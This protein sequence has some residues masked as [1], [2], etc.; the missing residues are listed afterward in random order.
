MRQLRLRALDFHQVEHRKPP[1]RNLSLVSPPNN[2]TTIHS[3]KS[4]VISLHSHTHNTQKR[5]NEIRRMNF[6]CFSS[7]VEYNFHFQ[8]HYHVLKILICV[9]IYS[10]SHSAFFHLLNV[11]H[12]PR[13][14]RKGFYFFIRAKDNTFE[15]FSLLFM[16]FTISH[17]GVAMGKQQSKNSWRFNV[18]GWWW[19]GSFA[20]LTRWTI[21]STF[22][23][24]SRDARWWHSKCTWVGNSDE[25]S[26]SSIFIHCRCFCLISRL[27][28]NDLTNIS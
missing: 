17:V 6:L 12:Q 18:C 3:N 11:S 24:V 25:K 8:Y 1:K 4:K 20:T 14:T 22:S 28:L 16:N 27:I 7:S 26:F 13:A 9:I 10:F 23:I 5:L 2:P 21:F 15:R 19:G